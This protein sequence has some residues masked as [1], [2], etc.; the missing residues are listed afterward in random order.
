MSC[1]LML[2]QEP[3]SY[4]EPHDPDEEDIMERMLRARSYSY[5]GKSGSGG[6]SMDAGLLIGIIM[7]TIILCIIVPLLVC[8]CYFGKCCCWSKERTEMRKK[9]R[10]QKAA[11]KAGLA[12]N[13]DFGKVKQAPGQSDYIKEAIEA[14]KRQ[15][16]GAEMT[17]RI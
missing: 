11:E 6:K 2:H 7:G 3:T 9:R 15:A 17:N 10:Q 5:R 8:L 13:D 12:F 16:E 4:Y 14:E 1:S